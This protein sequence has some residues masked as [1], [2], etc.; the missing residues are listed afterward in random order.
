MNIIGLKSINII[1]IQV[2]IY[3]LPIPRGLITRLNL[4][5][6]FLSKLIT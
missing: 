3:I 6:R 2:I 1:D 4:L 5:G